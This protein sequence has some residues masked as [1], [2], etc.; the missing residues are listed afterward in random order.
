MPEGIRV[1][2][3]RHSKGPL[4]DALTVARYIWEHPS[5]RGKRLQV[6]GRVVAFHVRGRVFGKPSRVPCG[7]RSQIEVRPGI[8]VSGLVYA[9]PPEFPEIAVWRKHLTH[10]DLFIDVGANVGSYSIWAI[11]A[12]ATVVALEPDPGAFDLLTRNIALNG[13]QADIRSVAVSDHAGTARFSIGLGVLNH[14]VGGGEGREVETVTLDDV[15]G[16]R[17]AAGVKVD[18]EGA[19]ALVVAGAS[20]ALSQRR[21]G[22][23]QLEWNP[24]S[25]ANFG[26][27]R[28]DLAATLAGYGY[29]IC[30]PDADGALHPVE[31]VGV[32]WDVFARPVQ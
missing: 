17:T 18:V 28:E 9:N 22:L 8:G 3:G 2:P 23:L 21:I 29:E 14:L 1:A 5:N 7:A 26:G 15:L 16:D 6:L 19:E 30:R 32:G 12:G 11:E 20:R 10:G 24:Q 31:Q 27:T 4:K 25:E 13:Y